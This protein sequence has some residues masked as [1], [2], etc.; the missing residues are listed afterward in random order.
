MPQQPFTRRIAVVIPCYKVESHLANVLSRIGAEVSAI[1]C[2][3]DACPTGSGE[4]ALKSQSLDTRIQVI[5][6]EHN[7]GVGDAFMT[8]AKKEIGRASCRERVYLAV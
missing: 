7:S 6:L 5:H 8:G 2:V 4:V 1:Y 3:I